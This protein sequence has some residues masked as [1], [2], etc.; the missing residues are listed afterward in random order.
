[1]TPSSKGTAAPAPGRR[2]GRGELRQAEW[3]PDFN[4]SRPGRAGAY[5]AFTPDPIGDYEPV[6][7]GATGE[8]VIRAQGAIAEL[9]RRDPAPASLEGLARQLLR[10]EALASSQIEGLS[11]S[12]RKLAHAAI[13]GPGE[14]KAMEILANLRAME[15]A[16]DLGTV[17]DPI[18]PQDI[19]DLHEAIAIVSPLDRIAGQFREEQGWIGGL[20]PVEAEFV[21][22]PHEDLPALLDDLCLF[23][24]RD[25]LPAIVQAAIAHAQFE[26][27]H[28]FGDGNGR[29]G[30]CL[31]HVILRRRGL[32][33]NYVPP[34]SLVLGANKDAYI[35][36][37]EAFQNDQV[38]EWLTQFARACEA[39]AH[40]AELF[41][42]AIN[43][44]QDRWIERAS[45]MRADAA[46]RVV[47]AN[48]PAFP[49]ITAK[50][51]EEMT[52]KSNVTAH[53][54]LNHLTGQDILT[55]H[56]NRKKGDAWEANELF[57]L[58]GE[59][60]SAVKTRA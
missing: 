14:H 36:G 40:H 45:P 60:E 32:A 11:I 42:S 20:S 13:T 48:L 47:I 38:E 41:S 31:I 44:L 16:I 49:Y 30:R 10:S 52:G 28:P 25:D 21:P 56:P 58:L 2:Q 6:L 9:N 27:M 8:L 43:A 33:P 50:I 34:I 53:N 37:L 59:F 55:K 46:A 39:S 7:S 15:K 57:V 51:V 18:T 5:E 54:A 3:S 1:M 26:T 35:A 12:H 23:M 24:N 17:A 22:P 19:A 29:I 4:S